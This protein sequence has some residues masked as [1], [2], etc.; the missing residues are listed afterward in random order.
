MEKNVQRQQF[1]NYFF[2]K[3][4]PLIFL[5][6]LIGCIARTEAEMKASMDAS[7]IIYQYNPNGVRIKSPSRSLYDINIGL[8]EKIEFNRLNKGGGSS[9]FRDNK[10]NALEK[11]NYISSSGGPHI[12]EDLLPENQNKEDY[13]LTSSSG[14]YVREHILLML[15]LEFVGKGGK[16]DAIKTHLNYLEVPV[17]ALYQSGEIGIGKII[18]GV[19]P[20]VAYGI[21]G[22]VKAPY[23]NVKS[24]SED[25]GFKRFDGGLTFTAGYVMTNGFSVSLGYDLGLAN[26]SR[27]DD[28]KAKNRAFSLNVGYSLQKLVDQIRK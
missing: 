14:N 25:G 13:V 7:K 11:G 17:Y 24:F 26:I 8:R 28:F 5:P 9:Y 16:D 12:S 18:G 10:Y 3:Y 22:K 19:G 2:I 1:N 20:Y 21:G 23:G 15:G 6:L 27:E 4:L